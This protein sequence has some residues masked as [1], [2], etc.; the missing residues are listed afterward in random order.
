MGL[1]FVDVEFNRFIGKRLSL[2]YF[3]LQQDIEEQSLGIFFT[4]WPLF[5]MCV[6]MAVAL[7]WFY[8]KF[9]ALRREEKLHFRTRL[10]PCDRCLD[11]DGYAR[12][13]WLQA[14][15]PDGR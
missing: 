2:E 15:P 11:G 13:F 12:Q 14:A 9:E 4:Y 7:F 5:L 3:L 8:P 10:A 1:N 6:S